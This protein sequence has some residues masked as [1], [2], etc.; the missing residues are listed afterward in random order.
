MSLLFFMQLACKPDSVKFRFL[1]EISEPFPSF[2]LSMHHCMDHS[3]YPPASDGPPSAPVYMVFQPI[4]CTAPC[5]ATKTGGLL[6]RLF[7]LTTPGGG[8]FLLHCYILT[9]IFLL[10]SMVPFVARTFLPVKTKRWNSLLH[11]KVN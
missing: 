10:G 9:D 7:T 2:I 5:V 1:Q 8:H 3:T 11:C 6:P 4:R